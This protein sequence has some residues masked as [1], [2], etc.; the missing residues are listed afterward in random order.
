LDICQCTILV[1]D[2]ITC[3]S[4]R[5]HPS[6]SESGV[7]TAAAATAAATAAGVT[8]ATLR[9][10]AGLLCRRVRAHVSDV[11]A[12]PS[13]SES[14]AWQTRQSKKN[15]MHGANVFLSVS[16]LSLTFSF[17][18]CFLV[19]FPH[20]CSPC[21]S[22]RLSLTSPLTPPAPPSLFRYLGLFLCLAPCLSL[23]LS[24]FLFGYVSPS[25][26]SP[27]SLHPSLPTSLSLSPASRRLRPSTS[28]PLHPHLSSVY[29]ALAPEPGPEY[30]PP[31]TIP[32][33]FTLCQWPGLPP[34]PLS[35]A[36]KCLASWM[37]IAPLFRGSRFRHWEP[38]LQGGWASPGPDDSDGCPAA[39]GRSPSLASHGLAAYHVGPAATSDQSVA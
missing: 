24:L 34:P 8:G 10:V 19:I 4:L 25:L 27:S 28:L 36:A 12:D 21:P 7:T 5:I 30:F 15:A 38:Q 39:T 11:S 33:L 29:F 14:D 23:S 20:L 9:L 37:E 2:E 17:C 22:L 1:S 3:G 35:H 6:L 13:L 18:P 16:F 31:T 26:S 32:F